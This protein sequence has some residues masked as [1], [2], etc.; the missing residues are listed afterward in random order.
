MYFFGGQFDD[1]LFVNRSVGWGLLSNFK[2][3]LKHPRWVEGIATKRDLT[4]L[5]IMGLW[6]DSIPYKI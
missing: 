5:L 3:I 2:N 6:M 4:T 1:F